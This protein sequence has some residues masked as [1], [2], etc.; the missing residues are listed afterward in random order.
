MTTAYFIPDQD[1]VDA[2]KRRRAPWRRRPAAGA[3]Q[4]QPHRRRLDLPRLLLPAA[5]GRRADLPVQGRD[6]AREDLDRRRPVVD[7][8]HRE[9][10]PAQPQGN[11]EINVE[12][13]DSELAK[14]LEEIWAVDESNCIE[15]TRGEWQAR[16]LHRRFTE[17]VLRPLRPLL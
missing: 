13:I 5:R 7:G 2:M 15:L 12:V 4:V 16:D 8:R 10:R 17:L 1:F 14:E 3:A 11:Y 6:G 9:H